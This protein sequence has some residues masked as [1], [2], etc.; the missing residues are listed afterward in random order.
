M[1]DKSSLIVLQL[2]DYSG[3]IQMLQKSTLIHQWQ[4]VSREKRE[5]ILMEEDPAYFQ[6]KSNL[7]SG[8]HIPPQWGWS[9][10]FGFSEY[11]QEQYLT[12]KKE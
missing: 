5:L 4:E 7:D 10:S 1:Y 12:S 9:S 11:F 6:G 2:S 3:A 8:I